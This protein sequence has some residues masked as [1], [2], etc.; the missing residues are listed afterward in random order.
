M[1]N[2]I[3][4]S[5]D[6]V[7]LPSPEEIEAACAEIQASWTDDEFIARRCVRPTRH[8]DVDGAKIELDARD[9]LALTLAMAIRERLAGAVLHPRVRGH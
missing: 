2:M 9:R 4:H 3:K 6:C 7:Y 5:S 1:G 8:D